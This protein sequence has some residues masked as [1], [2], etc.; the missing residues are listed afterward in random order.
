MRSCCRSLVVLAIGLLAGCSGQLVRLDAVGKL[1]TELAPTPKLTPVAA[2]PL[3]HRPHHPQA[4][5][6]AVI[7]VDGL[8]LNSDATGLGSWGE[9]PVSLFR[10]RLDTIERDPRIRAVVVRINSPGGSVTA[11]DI[12][13]RDLL[14][15]KRRT[16]LPVVACLMDVAAGGAYYLATSCDE[17]VAH[18]T[19]ITGAIGCILNVYNLQDMMAQ[20]N[21]IGVPIKAGNKIDLGT[22]IKALDDEHRELLQTMADEFHQRFR[23]IVVDRRDGVD[24]DESSTFDGRVFTAYQAL[25]RHLVDRIGYL[26]DAIRS[27]RQL[28]GVA[29]AEVMMLHRHDDPPL[30]QYATTPNTP[31]QK[32]ILPINV[33]GLDRSRL[34][35]FLYMWQMEP[36]TETL[37]GK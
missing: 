4:C 16:G 15:F 2:T 35:C 5:V 29:Q 25:D 23:R 31:L 7:D 17:I 28:A 10:E 19:S 22:P 12:M 27:A 33:P 20:F 8:L 37:L 24:P 32:T 3:P 6:V 13:W 26:D 36:S 30:S 14:A 18:P 11:S 9:N 21:I 1:N 34:P